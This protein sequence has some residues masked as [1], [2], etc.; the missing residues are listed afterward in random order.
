[1]WLLIHSFNAHCISISHI[2]N[3]YSKYIWKKAKGFFLSILK[4]K[5]KKEKENKW[6][7]Y[8][9][10]NTVP[11]EHKEVT[12]ASPGI[13]GNRPGY[14]GTDSEDYWELTTEH[15][16]KYQV[17]IFKRTIYQDPPMSYWGFWYFMLGNHLRI[18]FRKVTLTT[19]RIPEWKKQ[20]WFSLKS[21]ETNEEMV[22]MI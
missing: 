8:I 20:N 10:L 18:C 9:V 14:S 1:M 13:S 19:K 12:E 16:M 6:L 15:V 2:L 22:M 21:R 5:C 17:W 3:T 11:Q 4:G 7:Q